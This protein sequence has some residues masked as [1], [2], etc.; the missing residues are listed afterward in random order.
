MIKAILFD[1]D[2]TLVDSLEVSQKVV[3][4]LEQ[5]QGIPRHL[6]NFN[7]KKG[8]GRSFQDFVGEL[9]KIN[10]HK[11][12]HSQMS[13]IAA[14]YMIKHF[15][16][17]KI[18][19]IGF[20][21]ELQGNF[22]LAIISHN[23]EPVVKAVIN[24]EHNKE[25]NFEFVLANEKG[26]NKSKT[27]LLKDSLEK[28]NLNPNEAIYVGD[29]PNDILAAKEVGVL[30]VGIASGLYSSEE[31]SQYQPDILINNLSELRQHLK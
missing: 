16:Q 13:K 4:D 11:L 22:K 28:L 21:K 27:E 29:H 1:F 5:N 7:D 6:W 18:K 30:S 8:W 20:L 23:I 17:I 3:K 19:E 26:F 2:L 9:V 12:T 14:G 25:L 24:N 15:S 10:G 31:L